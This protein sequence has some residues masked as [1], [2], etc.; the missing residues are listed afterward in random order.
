[1]FEACSKHQYKP[2]IRETR[3]CLFAVFL[4]ASD[5]G[6]Y[7][8]RWWSTTKSETLNKK[9]TPNFFISLATYVRRFKASTVA[10]WT[11][12]IVERCHGRTPDDD[13]KKQGMSPR[14]LMTKI[15]ITQFVHTRCQLSAHVNCL[16]FSWIGK[17]KPLTIVELP[18]YAHFAPIIVAILMLQF[19]TPAGTAHRSWILPPVGKETKIAQDRLGVTSHVKM[20]AVRRPKFN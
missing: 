4:G 2:P 12:R 6:F 19:F 11:G 1:V 18:L 3:L 15:E 5:R 9:E 10:E 8:W 7:L 20:G 14:E 13:G 16:V 17:E